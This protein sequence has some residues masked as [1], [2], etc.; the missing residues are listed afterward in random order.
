MTAP[1]PNDI[2]V[3]P[4]PW[5]VECENYWF[6]IWLPKQLPE[7]IY[8]PLEASSEAFSSSAISGKFTAGLGM[9]QIYRY[10]KTPV[11]KWFK[12]KERMALTH[13]RPVR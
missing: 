4:A 2:A 3:A 1:A 10:S 13:T 5:K 11:G 12:V 7:G 9:I 6:P 8:D